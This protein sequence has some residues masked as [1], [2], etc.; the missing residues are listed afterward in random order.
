M[1]LDDYFAAGHTVEQVLALASEELRPLPQDDA[2]LEEYEVTPG[3]LIWW[4]PTRDDRIPIRLTNFPARIIADVVRDDGA[5]LMHEFEIEA[6]VDERK[7]RRS[8]SA[9]KF[10]AMNWPIEVLGARAIVSPGSG[11][12]DHARAAIQY[13]S[14]TVLERRVYGHPGW[15]Q[16]DGTWVY[17]HAN[18]AIGADEPVSDIEIALPNALAQVAL[19]APPTGD[20]LARAITDAMKFLD[21]A[22]KTV[23]VPL[24]AAIWRAALAAA[25]FSIHLAG[26][27][28]SGKTEL[29]ALAQQHFGSAMTARNLPAS[30]SSTGNA[31]EE[32]AFQAKDILLVI[33][34]F[35]PTG[36][37]LDVQRAQRDAD[38]VLRAQGNRSGRQRMRADGTLRPTRPP[39]GLILSTGEDVPRGQSLRSRLLVVE[40][41]PA[42]L[43]LTKLTD[44]QQEAAAGVYATA[45]AG[46]IRWL[47]RQYD[48]VRR[49]LPGDIAR[50][51]SQALADHGGH[52]RTPDIVANL[53]IG[54][55]LFIEYA[56]EG[57]ALTQ[58]QADMRWTEAW[59]VLGEAAAAQGDHQQTQEPTE[60][61]LTLVSAALA[62]GRAH[63]ATPDGSPPPDHPAAWG[64]WEATMGTGL[65]ERRDWRPQGAR[66]GWVREDGL[67][68][69]PGASYAVAQHLAD[70]S[71]ENLLVTSTTLRKRLHERG[72]LASVD[73][74]RRK[75][76]VRRNFE[77][78]RHQVLH[79]RPVCLGVP[80]PAQ[81][82]PAMEG[83]V[84]V[85]QL[86]NQ[87]RPAES[88]HDVRTFDVE[89]PIGPAAETGATANTTSQTV[90]EFEF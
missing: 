49:A 28:G 29:A 83:V 37:T 51:R 53:A 82:A 79:L 11:L 46:F 12:R 2:Q 31:L 81:S 68:L 41:A 33:D 10:D 85:G 88:A 17:L 15:R 40:L 58:P 72:L 63:V 25:D 48:Q 13:L 45:M 62:S 22:P 30:W 35:V 69:E 43:D 34:D 86:S 61:F 14:G 20:A 4:R 26:P 39:R 64:W 6:T 59:R 54:F 56:V 74:Q 60:Q 8:L 70:E 27:T 90:E 47:A 9:S 32:L 21:L 44:C 78:R 38:R 42:D 36:T 65:H 87:N 89:G 73:H 55:R 7:V 66:I 71:R 18:G 5:E 77:G 75:L 57:G 3:G 50:Y 67:Y 16:I 24:F 1:G 80:G 84:P 19:P 76:T 52:R 23:T